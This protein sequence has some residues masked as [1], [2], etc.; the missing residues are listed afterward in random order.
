MYV[1]LSV[2]GKSGLEY[3][4]LVFLCGINQTQTD[5]LIENLKESD[6]K[7]FERLSLIKHIKQK[8][9]KEHLYTSLRLSDLGKTLLSEIEEAEI[10]PEDKT[11]FE[12]LKNYYIKSGKDIGNGAKTQRH[13]RDFRLKSGI[14]KNNLINLV[15]DFLAENEERSKKLE[16]IWYYPKTAFATRFDLEESWLWNHF[17]KNRERLEKTFEEY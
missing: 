6:Y 1:N 8:S 17:I 9:K 5:W 7:R 2:L 15:L 3:S 13:I 10:A 4:D 12:W 11:V 14:Q 16:Y